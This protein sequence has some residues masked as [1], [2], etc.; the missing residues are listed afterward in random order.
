MPS[1]HLILYCPLLL[2]PSIFPR[3]RVF[4]NE[5]ALR[6]RWPKYWSFSFSMSPT[7]EYSGLISFRMDWLDLLAVQET[8]K[9]L[10]QHHSSKA[11]ILW[12]SAFFHSRSDYPIFMGL[13]VT[14][15]LQGWDHPARLWVAVLQQGLL[16]PTS[17]L[18]PSLSGFLERTVPNS[19]SA[20]HWDV[21][22]RALP[23]G[24][25][26]SLTAGSSLTHLW[27]SA[28][29]KAGQSFYQSVL[30]LSDGKN[31]ILKKVQSLQDVPS[32][33]SL[34]FYLP[35]MGKCLSAMLETCVPSLS[36]EDPLEK[37]MAPHSSTLAWKIQWTEE[38]GRLQS[39][40]SQRVRHDEAISLTLRAK[41]WDTKHKIHLC[42]WKTSKESW[43]LYIS[44]LSTWSPCLP[45]PTWT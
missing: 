29:L 34:A 8:F 33:I 43:L 27:S 5:P 16:L 12:R 13:T 45:L 44:R 42:W 10:L 26:G 18:H 9:S 38:P 22:L 40:G 37:E 39:T 20:S 21:S 14:S 2:L 23:C 41:G 3:I 17:L 6:I 36:R 1:N 11:P 4:S 19:G 24:T 7:N 25:T 15:P 32:V 30:L 35:L 31:V 28:C